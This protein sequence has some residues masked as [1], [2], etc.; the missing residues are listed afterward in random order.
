MFISYG[1]QSNDSLMQ[2]YGFSEEGNTA[3][4][5]VATNLLK[6]LEQLQPISQA[7]L[8]KLSSSGLLAALQ[9]VTVERGG[10]PGQTLQG[11]RCGGGRTRSCVGAAAVVLQAAGCVVVLA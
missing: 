8:D 1:T 3:D 9:E 10:F 5:Y 7:R 6:W 11:L 2:F 4:V